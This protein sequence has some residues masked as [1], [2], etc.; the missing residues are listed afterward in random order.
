MKCPGVVL[1]SATINIQRTAIVAI[2][3]HSVIRWTTE[4]GY[5]VL[6]ACFANPTVHIGKIRPNQ[7]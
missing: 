1:Q 6:K 2:I 7:N 4:K 3:Y 5:K